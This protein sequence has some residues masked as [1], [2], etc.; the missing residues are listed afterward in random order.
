MLGFVYYVAP[1]SDPHRVNR[2]TF[3]V[4]VPPRIKHIGLRIVADVP[5]VILFSAATARYAVSAR[6][7]EGGIHLF[8]RA[9]PLKQIRVVRYS[10]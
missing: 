4:Q 2:P 7:G 6:R 8:L 10:I 3:I 9:S 1:N 5:R